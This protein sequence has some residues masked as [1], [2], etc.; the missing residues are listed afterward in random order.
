MSLSKAHQRFSRRVDFSDPKALKDAK[1]LQCLL[2]GASLA[3]AADV[4]GWSYPSLYS[5]GIVAKYK[6]IM[7]ERQAAETETS[8]AK[9]QEAE[10]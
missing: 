9:Q 1:A 2:N 8:P 7:A 10:A 4:S 3:R 6:R 5:R